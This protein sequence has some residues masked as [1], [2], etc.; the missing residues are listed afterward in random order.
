MPITLRE[1]VDAALDGSAHVDPV[2]VAAEVVAELPA[3]SLR[4]ALA[5]TL[6]AYV[7]AMVVHR[8]G[9]AVRAALSGD[10]VA[11]DSPRWRAAGALLREAFYNGTEWKPLGDCTADDLELGA[12][13]R[14]RRAE[15]IL[16]EADRWERLAKEVRNR[17]V[18][19]VA[20]LGVDRVAEVLA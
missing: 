1:V 4:G 7:T 6:P 15:S 17:N 20:D 8:R 9:L 3:R 5:E 2:T 18:S 19:T 16:V 11:N 10:V 13:A 14:R 12:D